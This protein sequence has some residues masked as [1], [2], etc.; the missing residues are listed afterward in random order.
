MPSGAI[1]ASQPASPRASIAVGGLTPLTT[2]DYPGRRGRGALSAVVYCRG[3]PWR[4]TYCHNASL[5]SP[6]VDVADTWTPVHDF[7]RR[8]RGLLDAVVFSG[9]EPTSQKA[10]LDAVFDVVTLGFE[11]GLHTAGPYPGRLRALLPYL[12][13]I[14]MDVKAP[15]DSYEAITRVPRSG[16]KALESALSILDHGVAYE[17]R[18]TVDPA[19]LSPGDV[20]RL[21]E[22]LADLGATTY[23]LQHARDASRQPVA[24]WL[25]D[26]TIGLVEACFDH[27][28][29]RD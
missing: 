10:L 1:F 26:A 27:F 8:R 3:C 4:C 29:V 12:D 17:F 15:F 7:L 25:D 20:I 6:K 5:Q 16:L 18:T 21:A 9:G 2:I 19:V 14:G 28:E 23:V 24:P 11:V 22:S 13:W